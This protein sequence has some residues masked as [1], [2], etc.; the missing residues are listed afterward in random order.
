MPSGARN[1]LSSDVSKRH[2]FE[3]LLDFCRLLFDFDIRQRLRS[4]FALP[5]NNPLS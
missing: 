4:L 3:G 2:G 5:I 1:P